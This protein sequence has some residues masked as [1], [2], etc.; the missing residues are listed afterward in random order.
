MLMP[1]AYINAPTE[2]LYQHENG[3]RSNPAHQLSEK[4]QQ[5]E[6]KA[7]RRLEEYERQLDDQH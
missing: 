5:L 4:D 6:E 1:S 7:K 2:R 3:L